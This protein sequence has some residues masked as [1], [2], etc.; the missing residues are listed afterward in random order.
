MRECKTPNIPSFSALRKKQSS[1]TGQDWAN[2]LVRPFI[3]VYPEV[4]GPIYESW[5]ARKW[6]TEVSD[7]DLSPM[8]ADWTN[9]NKS[10]G[11]FYIKELVRQLDGTYVVPVRWVTVDGVVHADVQ[12]VDHTE[13]FKIDATCTRRIPALALESNYLD[14]RTSGSIDFSD[15]SMQYPMPHPLRAKAQGRPMFRLRVMPWC[16]DVSGNVSKQ[17]NAHTNMYVTNLNLRHQKLSQEYFVRFTSASP[18][19]SLSELF[20]A[21]GEDWESYDCELEQEI[22]FEIILHIL[23]VDNPQQSETSSHIGMGGNMQCHRDL[24]GGTKEYLEMN[25]GYTALYCLSTLQIICS[26]FWSACLNN[27]IRLNTSCSQSGVKDKISQYWIQRL[28]E[29]AK[30]EHHTHLTEPATR[31]VRLKGTALK[32]DAWKAVKE[33]IKHWIQLELW[34]LLLRQ[35]D[36]NF[37]SLALND[38]VDPHRATPIEI[39]HSYLLGNDKYVWHDTTKQ[40]GNQKQNLFAAQLSASSIDSHSIPPPQPHYVVKYKNSLIGKHFKMLQQLRV[41]YVHGL[42]PPPPSPLLFDLGKE[43][44]DLR[45]LL[46]FPEIKNMDVYLADIK[47]LVDDGLDLWGLIDPQYIIV[48]G[49]LH[50][51]P[52]I[53]EDILRFGPAILYATEIFE[54]WNGHMVSSGWWKGQGGEYTQAG[55]HIR[56]FLASNRELQRRLGWSEKSRLESGTTKLQVF[57]KR[58]LAVWDP[59]S[60]LVEPALLGSSW[61]RCKIVIARSSDTCKDASWIFFRQSQDTSPRASHISKVLVRSESSLTHPINV[62]VVVELFVV[63]D[64]RDVRLKMPI[65]DIMFSFNAQPD[66]QTHQERITVHSEEARF[67]LNMHAL[68]NAH[69]IR[70]VLPQTLMASEAMTLAQEKRQREENDPESKSNLEE[71]D[72]ENENR[73]NGGDAMELDG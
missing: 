9:K 53:P 2:P 29:K 69:L 20:V 50:T 68:H 64:V 59:T 73:E 51:F 42:C 72:G 15:D 31:D 71:G 11:H 1:L 70:E 5:Q 27:K 47:V 46:W 33:E 55:R 40:W 3:H 26:Q 62:V 18:Y 45:A 12:H 56:S 28:H 16:D 21:L 60:E 14:L 8:W 39:L 4:A 23:P 7:D 58:T 19:T 54:C 24:G 61:N 43:T 36:D 37:A 49:K 66:V 57:K 30:S 10:H 65:L 44:G 35:P 38:G 13:N 41:F 52:H 22:L 34:A 32:G 67:I 17:Y 48:K 25:T 6:T 63:L